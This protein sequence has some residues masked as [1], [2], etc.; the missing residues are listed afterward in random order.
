MSIYSYEHYV[1]LY[2]RE[3]DGTPYYIGKGRGGRYKER[4]RVNIPSKEENIVFVA[5]NLS[6]FEACI[7]EKRLI[8][9]YGRKDLGKGILHNQTDGGDGGDTSKSENYQ[10]WLNNIARNKDSD[11]NKAITQRMKENNPLF[12]PKIAAKC[13]TPEARKKRGLVRR[14]EIRSE[15]Q[16]KKISN[17]LKKQSKEL[18]ERTQS[19]WKTEEYKENVSS[20]LRKAVSEVKKMTEEEFYTWVKN[21]KL[22]SYD[23]KRKIYRP[24]SRVK[25]VIDHFGKTEEFY[26]DFFREKERNKKKS[27]Y[28]Y[29]DCSEEE[30]LEWINKQK[31]YRKDGNPNPRIIS[32][33]KYRGLENEYYQ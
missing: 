15:E 31:L 1:Y 4:H 16:R 2:L 27:W 13:H 7:L 19:L 12:D 25:L 28:Y 18:S 29:K 33:I 5:K 3:S 24:N 9:F 26:G 11:Y 32:V 14:G 10:Y 6:N 23:P 17:T 22:F 20:G 21:K 30:F 8:K